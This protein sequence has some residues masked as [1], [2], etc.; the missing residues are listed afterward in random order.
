MGE[1]GTTNQ[2]G[3]ALDLWER[4]VGGAT[5][6]PEACFFGVGETTGDSQTEIGLS[7]KTQLAATGALAHADDLVAAARLLIAQFP[8]LAFHFA[9]LALEEVGRST[10]LVMLEVAGEQREGSGLEDAAEDHV[11]KLFWAFWGPSFGRTVITRA[12]I[13]QERDLVRSVN[14]QRKAGLYFD[15][16]AAP[17]RDAISNEEAQSLI[18]MAAARIGMERARAWGPLDDDRSADVRWFVAH[19]RDRDSRR[20]IMSKA[21]MEKLAEL[22]SVPKWVAWLRQEIDAAERAAVE[23]ARREIAR[24]VP[25]GA[26]GLEPKWRFKFR[27]FSA[28]HSIRAKPLN[29]WNTRFERVKLYPAGPDRRQLVVEITL[30]KRVSVEALW[31]I[32]FALANELVLALNIGSNGFFWWYVPTA[33]ASR[34]YE[35]LTDL[36]TGAGLVVERNPALRLDWGHLALTEVQLRHVALCLGA[37]RRSSAPE[38]RAVFEHYRNGLALLAKNDIFLRF[39]INGFEQFYRALRQGMKA[40]GRWDGITPFAGALGAFLD[41]LPSFSDDRAR[42]VSLAEKIDAG[43]AADIAVDLEDVGKMK[44][45]AEAFFLGAFGQMRK[46]SG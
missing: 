6:A 2:G 12:Q 3:H 46:V 18:D 21:S 16:Y 25:G 7:A 4:H 30:P 17:P 26:E 42:Y 23:L 28:S 29:W 41:G 36:E 35:D 45:L 9:V 22:G 44:L 13:E 10:L 5:R 1:P 20:Q 34:F 27:L 38:Q 19:T 40:F 11:T 24:E 32:G 15:P 31:G 37:L 43:S 14:E 8:H 33:H 39:E